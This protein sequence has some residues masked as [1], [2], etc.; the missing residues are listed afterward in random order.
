P[1]GADDGPLLLGDVSLG[2]SA[3]GR[4]PEAMEVLSATAPRVL[5]VATYSQALSS[6]VAPFARYLMDRGYAVT[7]AASDEALV[8]P[9][10]F[11]QLEAAGFDTRVIRFTN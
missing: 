2:L 6:F 10:T 8:G 7:L 11:P 1:L 3:G 5:L 4:A 9:A